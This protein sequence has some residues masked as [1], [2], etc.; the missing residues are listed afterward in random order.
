M[1]KSPGNI[2][3]ALNLTK[4]YEQIKAIDPDHVEFGK[5][6][7]LVDNNEENV[8]GTKELGRS[9]S[10]PNAPEGR[11]GITEGNYP[12]TQRKWEKLVEQEPYNSEHGNKLENVK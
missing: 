11:E 10:S 3:E 5:E 12:V 8:G 2:D 6:K 1:L 7:T 4:I 9:Q